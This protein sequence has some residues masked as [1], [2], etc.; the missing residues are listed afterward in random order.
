LTLHNIENDLRQVHVEYAMPIEGVTK[1]MYHSFVENSFG[2]SSLKY[3]DKIKME[4]R[5]NLL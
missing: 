3:G 4:F 5:I 2:Q 1:D